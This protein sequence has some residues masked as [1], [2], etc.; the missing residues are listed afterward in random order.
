MNGWYTPGYVGDMFTQWGSFNIQANMAWSD[1]MTRPMLG[2]TPIYN[3]NN[4][5]QYPDM[6]GNFQYTN[7]FFTLGQMS[8]QNMANGG[9]PYFNAQGQFQAPWANGAVM[10][11][12]WWGNMGWTPSG[13]SSSSTANLSE[14]EKD[15]K[16]KYET[17]LP[18]VK[19]LSTYD[20]LTNAEKS[21][22][23][24]ATSP[25]GKTWEEKYTALK[26]AY[27]KIDKEDRKLFII[28][29]GFKL[30]TTKD[31]KGK[32][33]DNSFYNRLLDCG[34]E[35]SEDA[36]VDNSINDLK[37]SIASWSNKNGNAVEASGIIDNEN[38]DILDIISSWNT[39]YSNTSDGKRIIA[40]IEEKYESIDKDTMKETA[41]TTL[42]EPLVEKLISKA[43]SVKSSVSATSKTKIEDTISELREAVKNTNKDGIDDNLGTLFDELYL[44]TRQAS[45]TELRTQV[46]GY[47]EDIDNEVFTDDMFETETF[48]DLKNE[49]F[50]DDEIKNAEVSAKR[51]RTS[52]S[53]SSTTSN[54]IDNKT[55]LEQVEQMKQEGVIEIAPLK[56]VDGK[57][58][59]REIEKTGNRNY[60]RL[61]YIDDN[62][63]LVEWTNTY[64]DATTN[65][66]QPI[67]NTTEQE[68]VAATPSQIQDDKE[69]ADAAKANE[70]TI[71]KSK[72]TAKANGKAVAEDLR[73]WTMGK[74]CYKRVNNSINP[75]ALDKNNIVEFM[76]GFYDERS[77]LNPEGL[78]EFLDD[79]Y[80][81]KN[82]I[83]MSNKKNIVNSLLARAID[84]GISDND[85]D[86]AAIVKIM[87]DYK[88]GGDFEG[89]KT[90]NNGGLRR[91]GRQ[92]T[93]V[94]GASIGTALGLAII[95]GPVVW[96]TAAVAVLGLVYGACDMTT[97]NEM[98]DKHMKSLYKKIKAKESQKL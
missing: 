6:T 53:S 49:G 35:F 40:Y 56:T 31:I 58:V 81:G 24:D 11:N 25:T 18:L 12:S 26:T 98:L 2:Q 61:Y 55:A 32:D 82:K 54:E 3:F 83:E 22:L 15:F 44:L 91:F 5:A 21:K 50:S 70:V 67:N 30:G 33:D 63:K 71:Q 60:R 57:T 85:K 96:G 79:E 59:Y 47:Y 68:T 39:K 52:G 97:D 84:A 27:M 48:E 87:N 73:G 4:F 92:L 86:Y 38:I 28:E 69:K 93:G 75:K 95:G 9:M 16:I 36:G 20:K 72:E 94:A 41:K 45:I 78:I 34:F 42:I 90:F 77:F 7:P 89:K 29:N 1:A 19:E 65:S 8:W 10:N 88:T 43:N 62:N 64:Y 51:K 46:L 80:D 14:E 74:S 66:Y 76:E 17:L 13:S 23:K 37:D